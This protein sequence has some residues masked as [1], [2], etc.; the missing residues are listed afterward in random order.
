MLSHSCDSSA[1]WRSV[2]Q[3][4]GLLSQTRIAYA[5]RLGGRRKED[6]VYI[7]IYVDYS[8]P[9]CKPE[10]E[11]EVRDKLGEWLGNEWEGSWV[12]LVWAGTISWCYLKYVLQSL[13]IRKRWWKG[14][15]KGVCWF[16]VASPQKRGPGRNGEFSSLGK[17]EQNNTAGQA[18]HQSHGS[19]WGWSFGSGRKKSLQGEPGQEKLVTLKLTL[20]G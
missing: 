19:C 15:K 16:W 13:F 10:V 6:L 20:V 7:H 12:T 18:A 11:E 3:R 4:S 14:G 8:W 9:M 2:S 5:Q 17:G 1:R